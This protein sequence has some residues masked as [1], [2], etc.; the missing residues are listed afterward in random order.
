MGELAQKKASGLLRLSKGKVI[1]A[2][3]FDAGTP[4]FAIS[5]LADEQLDQAL[6]KRGYVT[7]EQIEQGKAKQD[8]ATQLGRVLVEMG[9]I[10]DQDLR[11]VVRELIMQIILSVFE[12]D[13]GEYAFDERVRAAHEVQLGRNAEE[14]LL[15][16]ARHAAECD[17]VTRMMLPG[18]SVLTQVESN[19]TRLDSLRLTSIESYVFSRLDTPTRVEDVGSLAGIPDDEARRALCTL[20]SVGLVKRLGYERR[21]DDR[22]ADAEADETAER[23][24]EEVSR[25]LHFFHTA[26]FYEVLDVTK[27]AS[28]AEIK[29]AYYQLAKRFHPDVYRQGEHADLRSKLEALFAKISQAYETLSDPAQRAAYDDRTKNASPSQNPPT[30]PS[31]A[32]AEPIPPA[33][34][35]KE[36]EPANDSEDAASHGPPADEQPAPA[37]SSSPAQ[38][39][40]QQAE[41]YYQQGRARYDAKDYYASVQ[42]LREAVRLDSKKPQYHFHLG[43][44]LVQN[45]RTRREGESHLLQAAQLDRF[46]AQIRIRLGLLYKEAGLAKKAEG[47]F[48]EALSIDPQN[49]TAQRE[50]GVTGKKKDDQSVWKSDLGSIAKK[51]FKK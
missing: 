8:K 9:A 11:T 4:V 51:L 32:H 17:Q 37:V 40:G 49:R 19:G 35:P 6:V 46:N 23:M 12:W 3:F 26:D 27:R 29:A 16:G 5:N 45:P 1:K 48:K 50:L 31:F 28:S 34:R 24:R 47:Y 20:I 30:P 25:K 18:N 44:A 21:G 15:D 43:I 2:V 7:P 38:P 33:P 39:I 10:S 22:D 36:K 13:Q 42:L 14:C 41:F